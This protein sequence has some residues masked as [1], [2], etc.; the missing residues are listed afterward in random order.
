MLQ[1]ILCDATAAADNLPTFTSVKGTATDEYCE[2]DTNRT[3]R[4]RD[5][6]RL[7]SGSA[8]YAARSLQS[9]PLAASIYSLGSSDVHHHAGFCAH[10]GVRFIASACA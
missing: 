6:D 2:T 8:G 3:Q 10:P 5:A 4:E 1:R 9:I 7:Q